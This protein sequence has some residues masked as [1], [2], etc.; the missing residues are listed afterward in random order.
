M[1]KTIANAQTSLA[2]RLGE[3]S[4]PSSTTELAK[5]IDWFTEAINLACGDE[6]LMWFMKRQHRD[7][8]VADQTDYAMPTR[9]RKIIQVKVDGYKYD[10]VDYQEV[11]EKFEL[12]SAVVPI[13]P[14]YLSRSFYIYEDELYLIPTPSAAP[15]T[16]SITSLTQTAGT[17]TATF[18]AAHGLV[19]NQIITI[20]GATPSAFNGAQTIL[21]V[22]STTTLTFSIASA[23]SSPA[24]GT[25]TAVN[26][27]IVV[28]YYEYPNTTSAL[29][30]SSS[31]IVPDNYL[32][33]L[34]S[35]AEGRYWS[36]AFKRAKS[37]DAFTEFE[38]LVDKLK[39]DNFRKQYLAK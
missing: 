2:Y 6:E 9:W 15:D 29:T 16:L 39:K 8:T 32:N 35:Y 26:K 1:A 11:H 25:I 38:T 19:R 12:P 30:S 7:T 21:T 22:P 13:L 3:S 10:E 33:I 20:A 34:V 28:D 14:G 23:T 17:A 31:I 5:R 4:V 24:T 27:N 37:G 36:T 18:S